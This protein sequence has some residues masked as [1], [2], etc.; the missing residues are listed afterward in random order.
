MVIGHKHIL[1]V[2]RSVLPIK[3]H[4]CDEK[5]HEVEKARFF[6]LVFAAI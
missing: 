1:F 3:G 2:I 5:L 4:A 6:S